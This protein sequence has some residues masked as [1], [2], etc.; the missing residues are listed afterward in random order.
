[1]VRLSPRAHFAWGPDATW[2]PPSGLSLSLASLVTHE[3]PS[4]VKPKPN[5]GQEL[6]PEST[7]SLLTSPRSRDL[8]QLHQT[9]D[10]ETCVLRA[11][12]GRSEPLCLPQALMPKD[13][14]KSNGA[15]SVTV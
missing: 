9:P 14:D 8:Q 7:L 6:G 2:G 15:S 1:M 13:G 3:I 10:G 11:T 5:Q 4:R 12:S